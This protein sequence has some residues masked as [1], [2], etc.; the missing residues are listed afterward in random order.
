MFDSE[1]IQVVKK[2]K[3]FDLCSELGYRSSRSVFT[4][5]FPEWVDDGMVRLE[6]GL[7]GKKLYFYG[8]EIGAGKFK[9]S[10]F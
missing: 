3:I 2:M 10:Y 1:N 5:D 4:K 9:Y 7:S 6:M 8:L